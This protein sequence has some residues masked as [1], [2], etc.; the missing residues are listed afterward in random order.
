MLMMLWRYGK[1]FARVGDRREG[2][3]RY[4]SD[5]EPSRRTNVSSTL[6][7]LARWDE[8]EVDCGK[9]VDLTD[10]L[11]FILHGVSTLALPWRGEAGYS[12]VTTSSEVWPVDL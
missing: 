7:I 5:Q 10:L 8:S 6:Q 9:R 3:G 4:W 12:Q 11:P 2:V 1:R